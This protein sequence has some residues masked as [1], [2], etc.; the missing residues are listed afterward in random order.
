MNNLRLVKTILASGLAEVS[1]KLAPLFLIH[2]AHSRIGLENFGSTQ[3]IIGLIDLLATLVGLGYHQRAVM[4][5]GECIREGRLGDVPEIAGRIIG[6]R[7]IQAFVVFIPYVVYFGC[8]DKSIH[9]PVALAL[10]FGFFTSALDMTFLLI[11]EQKVIYITL[12]MLVA[13]VL[14]IAAVLSAVANS[15]DYVY[16][17]LF[18]F[19]VAPFVSV[20]SFFY[21]IKKYHFKLPSLKGMQGEFLAAIPF[22]VFVFLAVAWMKMDLFVGEYI[23]PPET[24][25]IYAGVNKLYI[26]LLHL[27][28]SLS[29]VFFSESLATDDVAV[30]QRFAKG[31]TGM[32]LLCFGSIALFVSFGAEDIIALLIGSSFTPGSGALVVLTWALFFLSAQSVILSQSYQKYG[33]MRPAV[34]CQLAN[35]LGGALSAL[36][37]CQVLD[38]VMLGLALGVLLGSIMGLFYMHLAT[39]SRVESVVISVLLRF[40][41]PLVLAY[42]AARLAFGVHWL[43]KVF[44]SECIYIALVMYLNRSFLGLV[45]RKLSGHFGF[46]GKKKAG[47]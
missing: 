25:G 35:I 6:L 7:L 1:N 41:A 30:D 27:I 2:Y 26:S 38:N 20:L 36:I 31:A 18:T 29:L 8:F 5:V 33:R 22:G 21:F 45:Y 3:F 24:F 44:L 37:L 34:F 40:L 46:L 14:G 42:A 11:A 10:S 4:K 15:G 47:H 12:F 43:V 9:A 16:F 23:L 32:L 28:G 17:A 13:R 19:G 39:C